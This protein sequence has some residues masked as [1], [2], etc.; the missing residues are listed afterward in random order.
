MQVARVAEYGE[1]ERSRA[2]FTTLC[3]G[4][5]GLV[6]MWEREF[7]SHNEGKSKAH[8][9][10]RMA[11]TAQADDALRGDVSAAHQ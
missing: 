4:N 7:R 3:G 9:H 2:A 6:V 5:M 8:H 11:K 10:S 1:A